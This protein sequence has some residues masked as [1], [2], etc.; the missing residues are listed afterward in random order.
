MQGRT[1]Y[2]LLFDRNFKKKPAYHALKEL[3]N[4]DD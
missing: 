1:D 3:V 4:K 2:P